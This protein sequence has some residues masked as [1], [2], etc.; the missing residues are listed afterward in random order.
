MK[1]LKDEEYV[2]LKTKADNYDALQTVD[3]VVETPEADEVI[4]EVVEPVVNDEPET[5]QVAE[6]LTELQS[7]IE[8]MTI[9]MNELVQE[10]DA[11]LALNSQ[12]MDL[13]AVESVTATRPAAEASAVATDDLLEF[14]MAHK[15]DTVAIAARLVETGFYRKSK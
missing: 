2:A 1:W 15:G 9:Q 8:T 14:A 11:L 3:P 7:Q 13:P 6:Q 5:D 4:P 10:R 12:L